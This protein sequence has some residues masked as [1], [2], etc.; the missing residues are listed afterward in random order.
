[1]TQLKSCWFFFALDCDIYRQVRSSH[2]INS[3]SIK[4]YV[5]CC[6][7]SMQHFSHRVNYYANMPFYHLLYRTNAINT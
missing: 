4:V 1:M 2:C 6:L 5:L 3:R 7:I